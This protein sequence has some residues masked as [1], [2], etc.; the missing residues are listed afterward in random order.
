MTVRWVAFFWAFFAAAAVASAA[1]PTDTETI[2]SCLEEWK[3]W[4]LHGEEGR[5]C[6]F[7]YNDGEAY[8]CIW[9][10]RLD[11]AFD[12]KGGRFSQQW[13][14]FKRT[15]VPLPGGNEVWPQNVK[16]DGKAVPVIGKRT[17]PSVQMEAGQHMVDGYFVWSEMPEMI[18][19]TEAIG[20]IDL[21]I[22]DI[23]VDSPLMDTEGRLWLQ[24]RKGPPIEAD[25]LDVQICRLLNDT[26]PMQVSTHLKINVSGHAREIKMEGLLL[27]GFAPLDVK[28]PLPARLGTEGDL[29]IQARPGRW[30]VQILTR[31]EGPVHKI[32]A[33][34]LPY[35]QE[36]WAY[37]SQNH[38]RMVK[39]QGVPSIDPKQADIP[40]EWKN[41][42]TFVVKNGDKIIFKQL[43]RG[44]P[45]PAPDQLHLER[46]WWLDF[47]GGGF[48]VQD[49]I[50]G[51]MSRQWYLAMNPPGLLGRVSVDGTDQLITSQGKEKKPGVEL[52]WGRLNLVAE[53]RFEAS[54]EI[55]PAVGWDHDFQ[56]V[57]GFLN[58][59]PGWRLLTASGVDVM[60]G[61]WFERWTLLDIF[62]GLIIS[63][64]VSRLWTW[65]W[66]GIALACI[67]LIYHEAGSPRLVWLH[68]LAASALLRFLPEHSRATKVVNL[69]R[70]ASIIALLVLSIPFIVQQVRWGVYPQLEPQM[71]ASWT[72]A[73]RDAGVQ[74]TERPLAPKAMK[75]EGRAGPDLLSKT[76]QESADVFP[77]QEFMIPGPHALTQTGP[78]VPD[79][80][81]RSF[82]MKWNG[83]IERGQQVRLWLMSPTINMA[84][85]FLRVFLLA[86]LIFRLVDFRR[87]KLPAS[88]DAVIA[89]AA[90]ILLLPCPAAANTEDAAYPSTGLLQQLKERLLE[91][92]DCLPN[93]ADS[94]RLDLAVDPHNVNMRFQIH[95]AME[96]SVPLPGSLEF[97]VPKQVLLDSRP[98]D[99]LARDNEGVLWILVPGGIHTISLSGSIPA[100]DTFQIPLPLRPYWV[101]VQSEGWAV[102]G[103][104]KR[105]RVEG[106]I[107]LTRQ[108]AIASEQPVKPAMSLPPYLH[109]ERILSLGL[110]WQVFT[111]VRRVTPPG[112]PVVT[113]VPLMAGESVTTAGVRVE[114]GKALIHMAP[115]AKKIEW[116][117]TLRPEAM[118]QIRAPLSVPWTET[119]VLDA[120]PVWHCELSGIPI[121]HHQDESGQWRPEWR[122]WP[123][124]EVTIKVSRP[125]GVV[126]Q[127][128]T[129]DEARLIYTPGPRF[130]KATLFLKLRSS[131]GGQQKITLPDAERIQLVK[132]NGKSQPIE[133]QGRVVIVPFR[134]GSQTI[135]VEWQ[136]SSDSPF[137]IEAPVVNLGQR[138]VNAHVIFQ[139]PMNRWIL[140][141]LGPRLG[142]AVLF[143]SY[144]VVI[145]FAAVG[146]G[147]VSWTPLKVRHWLLLGLGLTQAHPLVA[148]M[149]VGWL[150]ALGLRRKHLFTEGWLYFDLTQAVIAAWTVAAL[151]GLY[152]CIQKG[153]L[154]I[155]NMQIS[156]NGSSDF[157]FQW[158]QDRISSAMPQPWVLSLP[159]FVYR[160][161]MLLWALWLANS[162]LRWL[163]WGW[164][165]FSEGGLWK[166]ITMR[167]KRRLKT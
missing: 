120:S 82:A 115:K 124:E 144:L 167:R 89:V 11:L 40:L 43:R 36:I 29:T 129:I 132:I 118:I 5:F 103:V 166:K 30:E 107:K 25:R 41:F 116:R 94:P 6:P 97:W 148:I 68:L 108:T 3:P 160:I 119:W 8:R 151:I 32:T 154:G 146:L 162:L 24:K 33:M 63:L 31:S 79:W 53:S 127:V 45:D 111:K 98:A 165:C 67:A 76:A 78:G 136:Q 130:N 145:I 113:S 56:S 91:K 141:T 101:S 110:D 50:Q 125:E 122:P 19:I 153:L 12:Q 69:W 121:I 51:T 27:N 140:L 70:I 85:A 4:V 49:R 159:L 23:P 47:D 152:L 58:L 72:S 138:A 26:I 17:F 34:G 87:W 39:I 13:L 57:S 66:G 164:S 131:Q 105:G 83:P 112:T 59:P 7:A 86:F 38:L 28:S 75:A 135:D 158:T 149:I 99:G 95:A 150:L 157:W 139:M 35:G 71:A 88:G 134:P 74:L 42:P 55:I 65:R 84:L 114:D 15:W 80:K 14:V 109:V 44:D 163:R 77:D 123:G 161:L 22:N 133:E 137:F 106:S 60:P 90:F 18:P 16:V 64:A 20:L 156:G 93:C 48:T 73:V 142:P 92:P 46:T 9:P 81:W 147:R 96:T 155:P 52:R 143:W 102:Q 1:P 21:T 37:Q 100:G 128:V 62:L 126:G 54:T 117:S 61:T 104:D 10:S 2:P